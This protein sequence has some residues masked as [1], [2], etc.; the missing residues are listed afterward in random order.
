M[1]GSP[2][3][4]RA[5]LGRGDTGPEL[6]YRFGNLDVRGEYGFGI[7]IVDDVEPGTVGVFPADSL[8]HS[9]NLEMGGPP[10]DFR[11][12][13][14]ETVEQLDRGRAV[15][16]RVIGHH[17]E[18][19]AEPLLETMNFS[20]VRRHKEHDRFGIVHQSYR[21]RRRTAACHAQECREEPEM[22]S[23]HGDVGV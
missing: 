13:D 2:K 6:S 10:A 20:G 19:V 5:Q 22:N 12:G 4:S 15:P 9:A 3:I 7:P 23:G 1:V 11:M 16:H 8:R 18:V 21:L 17:I 14:L